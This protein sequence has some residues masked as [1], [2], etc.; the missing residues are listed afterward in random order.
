[1]LLLLPEIA[2]LSA[3]DTGILAAF[4]FLAIWPPLQTYL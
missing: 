2:A 1:M 4:L 3:S